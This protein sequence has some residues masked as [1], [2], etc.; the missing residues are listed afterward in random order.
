MEEMMKKFKK[1]IFIILLISFAAVLYA[2]SS[3]IV[4]DETV[5]EPKDPILGTVIAIGPGLLAHGFGHFWAE[6]YKT[7]LAL[8]SL[9]LVS[10]VI[11]GVGYVQYSSPQNFTTIGGNQDTVKRGGMLALIAGVSLFTLD[12]LVDITLAGQAAAQYNREH[13][14]EFKMQQESM[15]SG[16]EYAL[17]YNFKF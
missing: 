14:L 15:S 7:G 13:N 10:L 16:T 9:E 6:D 2:E 17:L 11:V 1:I 12:W 5:L 4:I 3:D 8:F